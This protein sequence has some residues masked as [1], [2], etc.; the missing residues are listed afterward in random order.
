MMCILDINFHT[1]SFVD[2]GPEAADVFKSFVRSPWL[3]IIKDFSIYFFLLC[4]VLVAIQVLIPYK[5]G[6]WSK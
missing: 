5:T 3:S 1:I 2:P 4:W 6:A